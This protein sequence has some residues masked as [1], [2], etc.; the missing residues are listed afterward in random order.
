MGPRFITLI[1]KAKLYVLAYLL[2]VCPL[3]MDH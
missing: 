1:S 3:T 2:F